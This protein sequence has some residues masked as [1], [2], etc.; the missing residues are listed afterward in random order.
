LASA[1]GA[2]R[3]TVLRDNKRYSAE[4]DELLIE[5]VD[6]TALDA[7]IIGLCKMKNNLSSKRTSAEGG[8][9]PKRTTTWIEG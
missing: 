6:S 9:T 4:L 2:S 1:N 3:G 7:M 8:V 5:G